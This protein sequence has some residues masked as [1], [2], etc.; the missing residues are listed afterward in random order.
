M[1][2]IWVPATKRG[3]KWWH[4]LRIVCASQ[5][6][7]L[8]IRRVSQR[9]GLCSWRRCD[10]RYH[11]ACG[12]IG[13]VCLEGANILGPRSSVFPSAA[14]YQAGLLPSIFCGWRMVDGVSKTCH[15]WKGHTGMSRFGSRLAAP[16]AVRLP[17]N[18]RSS[19]GGRRHVKNHEKPNQVQLVRSPPPP[20][21]ML[22]PIRSVPPAN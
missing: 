22:T 10:T 11:S 2:R 15:W 6:G 14:P 18:T 4:V 7:P 16:A 17:M 21:P 12:I 1:S 13:L 5:R 19:D 3:E 9:N 8:R 20:P